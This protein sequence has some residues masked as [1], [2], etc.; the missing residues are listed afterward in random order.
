[1]TG[2][3]KFKACA[4]HAAPAFLDAESTVEMACSLIAEAAR[5]G[6]QLIAFPESFLPGFPV[7]ASVQ[8]PIKKAVDAIEIDATR[9][10]DSAKKSR[11]FKISEVTADLA[12]RFPIGDV[13]PNGGHLRRHTR[14]QAVI[15]A[16]HMHTC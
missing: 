9:R 7:W 8:A 5:G 15:C 4:V 13:C 3:P 11:D 14:S 2:Y 1:M 6:A 12:G 10:R 16:P